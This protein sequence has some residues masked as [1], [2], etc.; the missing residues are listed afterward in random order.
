M[1]QNPDC[2]CDAET[3]I[4]PSAG[5]G[6]CE[7]GLCAPHGFQSSGIIDV[8]GR[9]ARS[10]GTP[11]AIPMNVDAR[12]GTGPNGVQV[13]TRGSSAL[14]P[15]GCVAMPPSQ[16]ASVMP[17]G[18]APQSLPSGSDDYL[19]VDVKPDGVV[20]VIHASGAVAD[21]EEQ[22]LANELAAMDDV[23]LRNSIANTQRM[24]RTANAQGIT[25][26]GNPVDEVAA[27]LFRLEREQRR[28]RDAAALGFVPNQADGFATF[29]ET[30]GAA[31]AEPP[32]APSGMTAYDAADASYGIVPSAQAALVPPGAA[33]ASY[34]IVP[35]AQAAPGGTSVQQTPGSGGET[36]Q[37]NVGGTNT[38]GSTTTQQVDPAVVAAIGQGTQALIALLNSR[39]AAGDA[40]R[41]EQRLQEFQLEL[42]R[43]RR[44]SGGSIT[45][46]Q[47]AAI[48][49]A[50]AQAATVQQQLV[51]ERA[52]AAAAAAAAEQRRSNQ[53]MMI[54][55]VILILV[56]LGGFAYYQ[57]QK[58]GG[59]RSNPSPRRPTRGGMSPYREY[60]ERANRAVG[61]SGR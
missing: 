37:P 26:I 46:D 34:G 59:S 13:F 30:A 32:P 33:C 27:M 31:V 6:S 45:T 43:I 52:Q 61:A 58:S 5:L 39:L 22:A 35:S 21:A 9:V 3:P 20:S 16:S 28:R 2:G 1:S 42:D 4:A 41:R 38:Q 56:A 55:V 19:Q 15:S 47:N 36:K 51:Q 14:R 12:H 10:Y 17:S 25:E 50:L 60:V 24:I 48:T 40:E 11:S 54:G 49:A 57:Q 44:E 23:V 18:S 8:T 7:S 53:M 29:I